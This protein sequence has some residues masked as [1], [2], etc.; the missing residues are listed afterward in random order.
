[1]DI[2]ELRAELERRRAEVYA[3]A[4][5][6]EDEGKPGSERAFGRVAELDAVLRLID[7]GTA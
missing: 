4:C 2:T 6:L 5:A 7:H 3:L 1:M